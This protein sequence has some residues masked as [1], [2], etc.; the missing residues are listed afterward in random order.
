[1]SLF[2]KMFQFLSKKEGNDHTGPI[3]LKEG[4]KEEPQKI[5]VTEEVLKENTYETQENSIN[6]LYAGV[7]AH[8]EL[9]EVTTIENIE[10]DSQRTYTC[11]QCSTTIQWYHRRHCVC[12]DCYTR[13]E[14]RL[15]PFVLNFYTGMHDYQKTS[16]IEKKRAALP[17]ILEAFEVLDSSFIRWKPY[18]YLTTYVKENI[19]HDKGLLEIWHDEEKKKVD[20][21]MKAELKLLLPNR[22]PYREYIA[23]DLE[24]TGLYPDKGAEIIEIAAVK[25][26]DGF[27]VDTFQTLVKPNK[28]IPQKITKIT[29][30]TNEDV[31]ESPSVE[32]VLPV[33]YAFIGHLPLVAHNTPFDKS[34]LDAYSPEP[35]KNKTDDTLAIVRRKLKKEKREGDIY[36]FKLEEVASYFGY[37]IKHAHRAL[38]DVLA[39]KH[40]YEELRD[41][42][43]F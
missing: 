39:V 19:H 12:K 24:T 41:Y 3:V 13:E 42:E 20:K 6:T 35:P 28:S 9:P 11:E 29:G 14:E 15:I 4:V 10:I 8:D 5:Q 16:L 37:S 1:M 18:G 23:F 30:I 31:K 33:F 27:V 22:K 40:I 21:E 34:F 2:Q 38:D 26:M 25:V 43:S 36:S 32:E 17:S 7:E